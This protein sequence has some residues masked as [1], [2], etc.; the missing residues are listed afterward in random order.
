MNAW[1]TSATVLLAVTLGAGF[2]TPTAQ[3]QE[4]K[5]GVF[6]SKA[7]FQT[8]AEGKRLQLYLTEKR[9][10]FK[11]RVDSKENE[12]RLLQQKLREGEFTLAIDKKEDLQKEMQRKLVELESI[13]QEATNNLKIEI[14]D[15]QVQLERKLLSVVSEV[16]AQGNYT[17]ILEKNTQVV[18][19]SPAVDITQTVVDRFNEKFPAQAAAATPGN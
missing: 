19:A 3:A 12:A 13:R 10:E 4:G 16:G 1:K 6:D 5:I 18:F 17:V 7:V 9:E 2:A 8:S 14:E 15:V 11:A